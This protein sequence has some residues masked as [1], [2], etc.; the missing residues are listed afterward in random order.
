VCRW[1]LRPPAAGSPDAGVEIARVEGTITV[2]TIAYLELDPH[3][4]PERRAESD[5]PDRVEQHLGTAIQR[6][7][8]CAAIRQDPHA[9]T[10]IPI[11]E[12]RGR[13]PLSQHHPQSPRELTAAVLPCTNSTA[14]VAALSAGSVIA[15]RPAQQQRP[16]DLAFVTTANRGEQIIEPAVI[17]GPNWRLRG[18]QLDDAALGLFF[19]VHHRR[20]S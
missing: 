1:R 5:R 20:P 14:A 9:V 18:G 17:D 7:K 13:R 16:V 3:A 15:G 4:G 19:A 2:G 8:H 11:D 10:E 12:H 6:A